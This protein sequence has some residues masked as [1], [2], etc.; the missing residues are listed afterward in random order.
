MPASPP[1]ASFAEL[2]R[3]LRVRAGLTQEELAERCGLTPHAISA[4]E[5]GART[6]PYPHTLR[7]IGEALGLSEAQ[8]ADLRA[9]VPN[10]QGKAAAAPP[11]APTPGL[12]PVPLPVP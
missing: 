1:A 9:S 5:R 2:L 12:R 6:R 3:A 8:Q 11:P 10:R 7:A 4:L